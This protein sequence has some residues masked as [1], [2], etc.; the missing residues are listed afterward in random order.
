M[1]NFDWFNESLLVEP[2]S[3]YVQVQDKNI[4]YLVW[5]DESKPGLFFINGYSAHAHWWD[6]VAPAFLDNFSILCCATIFASP[7]IPTVTFFVSPLLS[8]FI[9][10]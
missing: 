3:K 10:T 4:H 5:G 1:S 6:F 2:V 9:S 8:G 7:Q